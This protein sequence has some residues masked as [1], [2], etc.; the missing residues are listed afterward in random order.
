M[1]RPAVE[2]AGARKRFG[3]HEALRGV[4]L[5]IPEGYFFG[6]L[7]HNGAG[8]STLINAMAG[9]VRLTAGQIRVLGHDVVKDYARTR[10]LLGVVPQELI[11]D[12]FFSVREL[13]HLQSGYFGLRGRAQQQWIDSLL[14][15]LA[16]TDKADVKTHQL[17]G[18]MK[19]RL[20]IAMALVHHPRV[21]VLDEPTAGVDV[22]LRQSLWQFVEQL[23]RE[24]MTIILTTHYLEEAE[25]LCERIAILDHGR[26][27][28]EADTPELLAQSPWK[29]IELD[30]E[31]EAVLGSALQGM[32]EKREGDTW[33]F[34]V[35]RTLPMR[36]F[37]Q[38]VQEDGL[39]VRDMRIRQADL[40][41]VFMQLTATST[42][43]WQSEARA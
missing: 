13:L 2:F 6:L 35:A 20:L 23:H 14:H 34:R 17:S 37:L 5:T 9:L 25:R 27:V 1:S 42:G 38:W 30:V 16:L 15:H 4:D 24:G 10:R 41:Q 33:V 28:M 32:L 43:P 19:R 36:V 3:R 26:I 8:K 7:G 11:D 31:G 29:W 40:E 39:A 22:T 21:L 12:P 18:G